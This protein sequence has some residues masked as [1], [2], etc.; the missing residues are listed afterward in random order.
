MVRTIYEKSEQEAVD[1]S[2]NENITARAK[3]FCREN[4]RSTYFIQNSWLVTQESL[5]A[6]SER[7]L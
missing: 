5:I 4:V 1:V 2:T 7:F 6:K 3:G